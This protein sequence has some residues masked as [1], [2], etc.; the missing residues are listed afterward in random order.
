MIRLDD[1]V[2]KS[3]AY[4]F[5]WEPSQDAHVLLY[6]EGIVK[7]N[8]TAAEILSRCT[9]QRVADIVAQLAEEFAV[10]AVDAIRADVLQ[11]LEDARERG[12]IRTDA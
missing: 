9:G 3:P 10:E 8:A 5:R 1:V 6:P 4:L 12:W 11:F 2:R 7:L